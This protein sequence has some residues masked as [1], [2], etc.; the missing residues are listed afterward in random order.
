MS[1]LSRVTVPLDRLRRRVLW[2]RRPLAAVA[3]AVTAYVAVQAATAPP[4]PTVP[5]WTAARDL[6]GGT[7]VAADDVVRRPFPAGSV[8]AHRLRDAGQVVGR[9]LAAPVGR[10][11]A[12]TTVQVVGNSWLR[13]RPDLSAVPV[14]ITDA[15]VVPLLHTGDRVDLVAADPQQPGNATALGDATVLAVPAA[16]AD[17]DG[18]VPGRLVVVGVPSQQA[19]AVVAA[20]AG[21]F[22]TVVWNH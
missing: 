1:A 17:H 16:R 18:A 11:S 5:V 20:S 19:V 9:T 12:L 7:V 22:L 8:P 4:A 14:R 6:A 10:G 15:S 13:G 21:R 2:H 3:A